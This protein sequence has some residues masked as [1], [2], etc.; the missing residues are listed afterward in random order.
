MKKLFI[1]LVCMA[2]SSVSAQEL[3][4]EFAAYER[5]T[6][7]TENAV[8]TSTENAVSPSTENA[9]V[10]EMTENEMLVD[11]AIPPV[12]ETDKVAVTDAVADVNETDLFAESPTEPAAVD[13]EATPDE[14]EA[15][16]D[17]EEED[18]KIVIYMKT[19]KARIMPQKAF[20]YCDG[21][22]AVKNPFKKPIQQLDFSLNYGGFDTAYKVRNLAPQ[23][24]KEESIVLVDVACDYIMGMPKM[25]VT[26]CVVEN[27]TEK[28]CIKR[29]VFL[30]L[31][32]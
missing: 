10:T 18:K 6:D 7:E 5:I 4:P 17:E 23:Q 31:S 11:D 20:S 9:V 24:E 28:N 19:A 22:I 29:I 3:F 16:E 1:A 27:M 15:K 26:R 13:A 25:K 21:I 32:E 14:K 2:V 8:S 30:P 12:S